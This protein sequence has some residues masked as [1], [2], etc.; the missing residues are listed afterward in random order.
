MG[1]PWPD[2][3]SVAAIQAKC[4]VAQRY[5]GDHLGVRVVEY[6]VNIPFTLLPRM[7]CSGE[8]LQQR[9]RGCDSPL[10]EPRL[11]EPFHEC[12]LPL[13]ALSGTGSDALHEQ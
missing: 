8:W 11:L 9:W 6:S 2:G 1:L 10:E 7:R 3:V 5:K 12:S 13:D 4:L